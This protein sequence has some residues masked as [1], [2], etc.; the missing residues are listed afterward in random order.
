MSKDFI[1]DLLGESF[2]KQIDKLKQKGLSDEKIIKIFDDFDFSKVL[3]EIISTTA[4]GNVNY[5]ERTMYERVLEERSRTAEFMA[6]NEQIWGK[7]FVAS[8]AM[9]IIALEAAQAYGEYLNEQSEDILY[10]KQFRFLALREIH[11]RAC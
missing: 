7:G 2:A 1:M 8:D 10:G 9:Y 5:L 6:R 4:D 11:G 3:D